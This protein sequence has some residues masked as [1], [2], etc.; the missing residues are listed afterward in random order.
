[1]AADLTTIVSAPTLDA[2]RKEFSPDVMFAASRGAIVGPH[3]AA[4]G[5]VDW[6]ITHLYDGKRLAP[7]DRE[8]TLVALIASQSVAPSLLL[9]VHLYWALAEGLSVAELCETL[10]LAG[11]YTGLPHHT[12]GLGTLR[13]TLEAVADLAAKPEA[14]LDPRAVVRALG[15]VLR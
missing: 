5:Y 14:S 10:A 1:M 11:V 9:G 8:R 6:I 2:L 12:A 3:P 13:T 7:A 15:D 4:A